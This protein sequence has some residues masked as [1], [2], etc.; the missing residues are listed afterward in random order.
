MQSPLKTQS[1]EK[2]QDPSSKADGAGPAPGS[3]VVGAVAIGVH[4]SACPP[5][6]TAKPER[7][8]WIGAPVSAPASGP[9]DSRRL[10]AAQADTIRCAGSGGHGAV[11]KQRAAR[12]GG[13][14]RFGNRRSVCMVPVQHSPI[15]LKTAVGIA[16]KNEKRRKKK[17]FD[18]PI[19]RWR[20][21][22][23]GE[24]PT[25]KISVPRSLLFAFFRFFLP[26]QLPFPGSILQSE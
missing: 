3:F 1:S 19:R 4:A 16:E 13:P 18:V 6:A 17:S 11:T 2:L 7:C 5:L 10:L 26:S 24:R 20:R 14:R 12:N 22:P 15:N 25:G 21:H 8:R 23:S 9:A